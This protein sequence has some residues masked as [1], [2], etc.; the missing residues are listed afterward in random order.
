MHRLGVGAVA[1]ATRDLAQ[2]ARA[3]RLKQDE[4][5]GGAVTVT[6]LGMYGT[7]EFTAIINPP[8]SSILAVGAA[9]QEPVVTD[10]GLGVASVLRVTLSVD[11]RV[12]DGALAARWM[13]EFLAILE[14]PLRI[15][16]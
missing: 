9:R 5:A 11:H 7:E 10:G 8:Q 3:G 14:Q 15:L 12:I 6:N 13:R 2:R 16:A 4:L 1:A